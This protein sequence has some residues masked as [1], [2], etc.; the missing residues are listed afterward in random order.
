MK[1]NIIYTSNGIIGTKFSE[2]FIIK[3][4]IEKRILVIDNGTY[5]TGNYHERQK[6]VEQFYNYG[7]KEV[8]MITINKDN[9]RDILNY[10]VCY[11]M[12]GSIANL[13]ELV[14]TTNIKEVLG[15]FLEKGIYIGESAGSIIL[16]E[17]V[18]W[19]FDLKRGTKPKYD[20]IFEDYKGLGFINQHIYP[21]YN[22]EDN[23][24]I[25]KI[26]EYKDSIKTLNDG[27]YIEYNKI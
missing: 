1:N 4:L 7:A 22:K 14:H 26:E 8:E 5:N 10:D 2:E 3:N 25:K 18:E 23:N 13:V 9:T 20:R 12:G 16:D 17:D 6:N 24:G 15:N 21:H 19:Y 27:D 11:V